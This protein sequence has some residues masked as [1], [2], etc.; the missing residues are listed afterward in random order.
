MSLF[1][2]IV[3]K[4]PSWYS[5]GGVWAELKTSTTSPITRPCEPSI[6]MLCT[7]HAKAASAEDNRGA[8][9]SANI[10]SP[11]SKRSLP[12]SIGTE[13]R[14]ASP[15]S[16][17]ARMLMQNVPA[18]CKTP[19]VVPDLLRHARRRGGWTETEQTAVAVRPARR[20]STPAVTIVTDPVN[21]RIPALKLVISCTAPLC[22]A[23]A[24]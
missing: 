5:N 20:L 13:K 9:P 1:V 11:I 18:C 15:K 17:E 19:K 4:L 14:C 8:R 6:V 22:L 21:W 12:G 2:E 3:A 24:F 10:H 16:H 23:V 7:S